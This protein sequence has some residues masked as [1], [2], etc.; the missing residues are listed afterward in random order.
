LLALL[1]LGMQ[2]DQAQETPAIARFDQYSLIKT[3]MEA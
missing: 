3:V 2:I 1:T